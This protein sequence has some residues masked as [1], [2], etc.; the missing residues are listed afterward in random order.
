MQIE[1]EIEINNTSLLSQI[2]SVLDV[3]V[4]NSI[5]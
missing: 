4:S 5:V 2:V 3:S 1:T